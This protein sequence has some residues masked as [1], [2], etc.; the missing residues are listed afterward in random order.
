MPSNEKVLSQMDLSLAILTWLQEEME[1]Q[2]QHM[3]PPPEHLRAI[4]RGNM[5]PVWQYLLK[6]VKSQKTVQHVRKNHMVYDEELKNESMSDSQQGNEGAS[7]VQLTASAGAKSQ[8]EQPQQPKQLRGVHA[9]S[10][11]KAGGNPKAGSSSLSKPG[12]RRGAHGATHGAPGSDQIDPQAAAAAAAAAQKHNLKAARREAEVAVRKLQA[13]LKTAEEELA[14]QMHEVA[15]EAAQRSLAMKRNAHDRLQA[16]LLEAYSERCALALDFLT[17]CLR[18]LQAL[19]PPTARRH[20]HLPQQQQHQQQQAP[21]APFGATTAEPQPPLTAPQG[22]HSHSHRH[23]HLADPNYS[24]RLGYS[25]ARQQP[26]TVATGGPPGGAQHSRGEFASSHGAMEASLLETPEERS[27]RQ[28]CQVAASHLKAQLRGAYPAY[29]SRQGDSWQQP[30]G[31]FPEQQWEDPLLGSTPGG[32]SPSMR[33]PGDVARRTNR[34]LADEL[35]N[36]QIFPSDPSS[37]LEAEAAAATT[38]TRA[39]ATAA[40]HA[41]AQMQT[42]RGAAAAAGGGG[43][44]GARPQ[45]WWSNLPEGGREVHAM[46]ARPAEVLRALADVAAGALGLQLAPSLRRH[47]DAAGAA[48]SAAGRGGQPAAAE[49]V[50]RALICRAAQGDPAAVPGILRLRHAGQ[51]AALRGATREAECEQDLARLDADASQRAARL[52]ATEERSRQAADNCRR[53][54]RLVPDAS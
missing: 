50:A 34:T 44:G 54:L 15:Q 31:R 19:A 45:D 48:G 10:N 33:A 3:L 25:A 38:T 12:S 41:G 53:V 11:K 43:G 26:Q 13:D 8:L 36:L 28:A 17:E 7:K 14:R 39:A 2:P 40:A 51:L 24:L 27:I 22:R 4:C 23:S 47:L 1:Y 18:R 16:T 6:H 32:G 37:P 5:V 49:A 29:S 21:Y 35:S 20:Q 30:T 52:H 46:L 42:E 9:S